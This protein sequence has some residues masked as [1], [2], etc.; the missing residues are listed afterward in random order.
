M[1]PTIVYYNSTPSPL[2]ALWAAVSANGLWAVEFGVAEAAFLHAIRRRGP[3][4]P[5][6]DPV[7]ARDALLQVSAYLNGLRRAFDLTIDWQGMT[8]FQRAVR[9]AVIAIPYGQTATYGDIAA[10]V[11]EPEAARA[12]GRVNATNPIPLVIPCHRV[13]G[14]DGKLVGYGGMGGIATK[15][16]LLKME[17]ALLN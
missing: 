17:G 3:V 2:G 7:R 11:G 6:H 8:N 10:E 4:S 15:A 12:V 14:S 13:I 1:T 9:A 16:R 5:V